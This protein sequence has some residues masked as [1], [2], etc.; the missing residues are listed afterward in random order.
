MSWDDL[1]QAENQGAMHLAKADDAGPLVIN[2]K[3]SI[4]DILVPVEEERVS[5]TRRI[6]SFLRYRPLQRPDLRVRRG[7]RGCQGTAERRDHN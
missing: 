7:G 4:K 2:R 5:D 1:I 6:Q 3:Q